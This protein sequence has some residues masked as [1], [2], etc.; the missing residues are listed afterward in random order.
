MKKT[1]TNQVLQIQMDLFTVLLNSLFLATFI[2]PIARTITRGCKITKK[3]NCFYKPRD[4]ERKKMMQDL[5]PIFIFSKKSL[6]NFII[7]YKE[8]AT[9]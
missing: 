9:H 8:T 5:P 6:V 4:R 7:I 2:F 1:K 3:L